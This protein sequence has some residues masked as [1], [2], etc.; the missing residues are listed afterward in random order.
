MMKDRCQENIWQKSVLLIFMLCFKVK[1]DVVLE[2]LIE[3]AA[4][5]SADERKK[6]VI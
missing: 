4:Q 2:G 3:T 5:N 1:L 6:G